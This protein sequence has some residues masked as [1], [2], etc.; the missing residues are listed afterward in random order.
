MTDIHITDKESPAQPIYLGW[1]A[2]YG[3]S[4]Q[5][6]RPIRRSC[7]RRPTSSMPRSRRSTR[8]TRRSPFDFG[9]SLG[10]ACNNTQYNELRWYIDVIDGKVITPSSGAHVG[11]DTID[12]QKPYQAAGL[13]K[14]IPWYQVIGNHDQFWSG[15]VL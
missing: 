8:C 11:A 10:D 12:Y 7:S 13:D 14:S 5:V 15:C 1:R 6:R 4:Y 3:P 9:I 2:Q